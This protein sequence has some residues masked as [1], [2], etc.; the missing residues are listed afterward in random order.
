MICYSDV[1]VPSS[2]HAV[3]DLIRFVLHSVV[4]VVLKT[5]FV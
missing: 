5:D 4:E 3:K 2:N 1:T